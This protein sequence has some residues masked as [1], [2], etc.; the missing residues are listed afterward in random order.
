MAGSGR[1]PGAGKIAVNDQADIWMRG[2]PEL[3]GSSCGEVLEQVVN[4]AGP[5]GPS[6]AMIEPLIATLAASGD[7]R[8]VAQARRDSRQSRRGAA[9]RRPMADRSRGRAPGFVPRQG[10]CRRTRGQGIDRPGP[11]HGR[12][13]LGQRSHAAGGL[14]SARPRSRRSRGRSR[15]HRAAARP[16]RAHRCSARGDPGPDADG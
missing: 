8:S 6:L 16:G 14:T 15:D 11:R 1:G 3:V 13:S 5:G 4:A 7:R 2:D 10:A 9:P 12:R